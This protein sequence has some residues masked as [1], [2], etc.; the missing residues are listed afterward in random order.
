MASQFYLTLSGWQ[1]LNYDG[2]EN[3]SYWQPLDSPRTLST[4]SPLPVSL[5]LLVAICCVSIMSL[6]TTLRRYSRLPP[7]TKPLPRLPGIPWIGRL[8]DVPP[9]G[10]VIELARHFRRF[11]DKYGPIY[12]WQ[13]MGVTR[14]FV[15][16]DAVANDLLVKQARLYSD[17]PDFPATV[18][19]KSHHFLPLMGIGMLTSIPM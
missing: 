16:S 7:G 2:D 15:N 11:H 13:A 6:A 9:S 10:A 18:G 5:A 8:W 17:K 1:V 12:E 14:V 19:M 4:S 3:A